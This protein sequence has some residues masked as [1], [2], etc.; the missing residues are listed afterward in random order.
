MSRAIG[1][2]D[3][4]N[5]AAVS[6]VQYGGVCAPANQLSSMSYFGGTETRCY[7]SLMQL[8]SLNGFTYTYPSG[9]NNGKISSQTYSGETVTYTYDS[10]NRLLSASGSG[11]NQ[12]FGYDAFGNLVSK[13][14]S[15][16]PP[17]SIAVNPATNQIQGVQNLSYDLNGNELYGGVTYDSENR[18]VTAPG[19]QYAYDSQNKRIW[20]GTFDGSGNLTAQEV[21]S[22]AWTARSWAPRVRAKHLRAIVN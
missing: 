11:W 1:L 16:S 22:T 8:T 19:V 6:N 7:N 14:G 13:T 9:T 18:I 4:N 2:T 5:Y 3:Q 21:T 20:K 17:L 15:N 10:L 12:S